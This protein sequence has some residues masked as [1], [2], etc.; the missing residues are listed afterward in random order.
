[1][2]SIKA[3]KKIYSSTHLDTMSFELIAGHGDTTKRPRPW[4]DQQVK[5]DLIRDLTDEIGDCNE[6][7]CI[8]HEKSITNKPQ[9]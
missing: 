1:M 6:I 3:N 8:F 2:S 9:R 5:I 4:E 7:L